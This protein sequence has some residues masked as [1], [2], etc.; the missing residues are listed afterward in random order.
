MGTGQATMLAGLAALLLAAAV[1]DVR[2]R[3]I[4]QGVNLA[5]AIAAPL[6]WWLNGDGLRDVGMQL[7]LA[8]ATFGVF[9]LCWWRGLMGGGDVKLITAL[10]LW[11]P[12]PALLSVLVVM[13]LAGGL[14][15]LCFA[16]AHRLARRE[17]APEIPYGL[18]I[19]AGGLWQVYR[20]I[21]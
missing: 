14:V 12:A 5:I 7:L 21:S 3:I 8:A 6:W 19:V 13:A 9:W 15:T 1:A 11:F 2:H 16:T 20:T 4:P 10:A 18:A 17:G